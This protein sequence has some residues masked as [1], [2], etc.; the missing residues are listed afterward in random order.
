[1]RK[2]T[3]YSFAKHCMSDVEFNAGGIPT[4][5]KAYLDSIG[6]SYTMNGDDIEESGADLTEFY[7]AMFTRRRLYEKYSK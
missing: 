3:V 1:M 7:E 2:S 4:N 5:E 6:F